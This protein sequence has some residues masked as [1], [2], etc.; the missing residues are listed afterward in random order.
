MLSLYIQLTQLNVTLGGVMLHS[1][2]LLKPLIDLKN[3]P[4]R[5]ASQLVNPLNNPRFLIYHGEADDHFP[6]E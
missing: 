3:S 6:Y 5:L 2:F 1:G 4:S